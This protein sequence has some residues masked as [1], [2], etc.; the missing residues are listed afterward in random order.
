ME[1]GGDCHLQT[2]L[3]DSRSYTKSRWLPPAPYTITSTQ[4]NH[5][6]MSVSW[7]LEMVSRLTYKVPLPP[8]PEHRGLPPQNSELSLPIV[9]CTCKSKSILALHHH[10]NPPYLPL[11]VQN[12]F[13]TSAAIKTWQHPDPVVGIILD[14]SS[15]FTFLAHRWQ[16]FRNM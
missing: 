8:N 1:E 10:H 15:W 14:Q 4:P 13:P 6:D 7:L 9:N 16:L 3:L 11:P 5:S 12:I 2:L